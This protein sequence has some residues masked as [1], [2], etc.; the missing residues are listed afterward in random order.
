MNRC[1]GVIHRW[2]KDLLVACGVLL[3]LGTVFCAAPVT[4]WAEAAAVLPVRNHYGNGQLRV[5]IV[6]SPDG[7]GVIVRKFTEGGT[8]ELEENLLTGAVRMGSG[9]TDSCTGNMKHGVVRCEAEGWM[10]GVLITRTYK[11]YLLDGKTQI[12]S[13]GG[14]ETR[15]Y[16]KGKQHGRSE[17]KRYD[18]KGRVTARSVE[19]Y[20][21]GVK[22][23]KFASYEHGKL[24]QLETWRQGALDGPCLALSD[25]RER[26]GRCSS[27]GFSGVEKTYDYDYV[28]IKGKSKQLRYL[29]KVV[30]YKDDKAVKTREFKRR[31]AT[32]RKRDQARDPYEQVKKYDE[33]FYQAFE[34]M[35]AT[36]T[37][38][39]ARQKTTRRVSA[40]AM[41]KIIKKASAR[42]PLVDG[43]KWIYMIARNDL[44]K[45][46]G[47]RENDVIF[48]GDASCLTEQPMCTYSLFR[49]GKV[50]EL[51]VHI[52]PKK[53]R[54]KTHR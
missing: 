21:N 45:G 2:A 53:A 36:F 7:R 14:V 39:Q 9:K 51:T 22:H 42:P 17:S 8:L 27:S 37:N 5:E 3:L 40:D 28:E 30:H 48:T 54:K 10:G 24:T 43:H 46:V 16:R 41:K 33:Q 29:E 50:I 34:K 49:K 20:V 23:G 1:H 47:I 4:T 13:G 12:V 38:Q 25:W 26:T 35:A 32:R 15:Q 19:S 11:D 52:E 31:E 18:K 44:L 6:P